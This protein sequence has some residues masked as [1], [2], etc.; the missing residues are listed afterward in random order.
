MDVRTKTMAR[1]AARS[2]RRAH[3]GASRI[4]HEPALTAEAALEQSVLE[5]LS[6]KTSPTCVAAYI[7]TDTEPSTSAL[8]ES[9]VARNWEVRVP[10]V[11]S[12]H[13]TLDWVTM[14]RESVISRSTGTTDSRGLW[15]PHGADQGLSGVAL[16][17]IPALR[18]S[19]SGDRLGQGGGFYDRALQHVPGYHDGGP[20]RVG[21]IFAHELV[22]SPD[23]LVE[24]HDQRLDVVLTLP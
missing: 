14:D 16:M 3:K 15:S 22:D 1:A 21:L 7:S 8:I 10:R 19:V 9:L 6:D 2:R 20:L 11:R 17:V 12:D 13:R 24:P 4:Q 18:A 23:W 5:L